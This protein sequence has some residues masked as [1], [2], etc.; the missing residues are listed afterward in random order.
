M[1]SHEPPQVGDGSD[2]CVDGM[3][4]QLRAKGGKV[5]TILFGHVLFDLCFNVA[6]WPAYLRSTRNTT[7]GDFN[8]A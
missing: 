8:G 4:Q 6:H 3:I 1:I 7:D 5:V 2:L